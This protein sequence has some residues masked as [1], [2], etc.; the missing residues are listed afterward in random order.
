M[1]SMEYETLL[2]IGSVVYI[3]FGVFLGATTSVQSVQRFAAH[4][5]SVHEVQCSLDTGAVSAV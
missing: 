1:N 3:V 4:E 5:F 2:T